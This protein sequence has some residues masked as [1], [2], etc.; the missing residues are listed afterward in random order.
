MI[1]K[2]FKKA[3]FH[4]TI[5]PLP[6]LLFVF[7]KLLDLYFLYDT[8]CTFSDFFFEWFVDWHIERLKIFSKTSWNYYHFLPHS[9]L[10]FLLFLVS[11]HKC[12][13]HIEHTLLFK[14]K[15]SISSSNSINPLFHDICIIPG[16]YVNKLILVCFWH[17]DVFQVLMQFFH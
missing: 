10:H 16:F 7:V 2:S 4:C 9:V 5:S 13:I 1:C 14:I 6:N 12:A 8:H 11:M 15:M 17:K 3:N